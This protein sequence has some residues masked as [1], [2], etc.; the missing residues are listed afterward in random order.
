MGKIKVVS[1]AAVIMLVGVFVVYKMYNQPHVN[2]AKKRS[3]VSVTADNILEDFSSNESVAN[4]KYLEKIVEVTGIVKAINVEEKKGIVS[5]ETDDEFSNILCH[6]SIEE[7]K[8]I[9]ILKLEETIT[10]KGICTGF[11]MDVILVKCIII[12]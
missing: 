10:I 11:L 9:D 2:V 5:L 12:N 7:T 4:S 3:D 8:K 1:I 6:L